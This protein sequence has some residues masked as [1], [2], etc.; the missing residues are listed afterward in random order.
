MKSKR[1]SNSDL[2]DKFAGHALQGMFANPDLLSV[3]V[4]NGKR[5]ALFNV[6]NIEAAY[7]VADM[8]MKARAR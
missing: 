7:D 5:V 3:K 6:E 2:R 8:M 1:F 4:E